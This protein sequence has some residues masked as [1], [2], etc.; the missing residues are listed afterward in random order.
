MENVFNPDPAKQAQEAIF[1]WKLIKPIPPLIKFNNLPIQNAPSQKHLGLILDEKL[2]FEYHLKE[3]CVKFNKDIGIIK[4]LQNR[5]PRRALLTIYKSFVRPHLD[6]GGIIYDQPNNESFCHKLESY[7]YNAALATAGAIRDISQTKIY[8][9]LGLE[10]LKFRRYFRRLCTFFKI[11]QSGLPS[12]LDN[13][14][15][16][17]NHSYNT[18]ELDKVESFYC[19]TDVFKN[20]FFPSVIDK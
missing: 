5:L 14:I 20:S 2:N 11:K 9:E 10:S 19:K 7:Q 4:K 13:L 15:P 3:N 17:S 8:K 18:R 6:Y 1:S 16:K 12:Y